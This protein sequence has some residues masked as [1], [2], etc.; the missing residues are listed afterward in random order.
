MKLFI[1]LWKFT[2]V[3]GTRTQIVFILILG[4]QNNFMFLTFKN[5]QNWVKNQKSTD[6][7]SSFDD[8]IQEDVDLSDIYLAVRPYCL[9]KI[10]NKS[11]LG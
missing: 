4:L 9:G 10:Q 3:C 2:K 6:K 5:S 11:F 7:H 8:E 1:E